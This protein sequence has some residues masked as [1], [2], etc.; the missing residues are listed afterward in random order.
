MAYMNQEKKRYLAPGIKKVL[1]KYGLRG[2]IG[3]E[4]YSGL[5]VRIWEGPLDFI[6]NKNQNMPQHKVELYGHS[7]DYLQVNEHWIDDTYSGVVKECLNELINAM[8]GCKEIQNH[9][10]DN[11][12]KDP[13]A[14]FNAEESENDLDEEFNQET[15]E[16]LLDI[17]TFLRR[18]AN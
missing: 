4:H 8:N 7:K 1:K 16:E 13:E 3:V 18:Q 14:E 11:S 9:D 10:T 15:E 17:P 5:K 6:G 2:T 12:D